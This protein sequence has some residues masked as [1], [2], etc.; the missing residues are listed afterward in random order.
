MLRLRRP[1]E[2][3]GPNWCFVCKGEWKVDRP[4]LSSLSDNFGT[5]AV[6]SDKPRFIGSHRSKWIL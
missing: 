6:Y 2:S 5:L 1:F 3:L 4:S